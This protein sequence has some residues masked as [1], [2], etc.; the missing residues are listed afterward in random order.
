MPGRIRLRI[1]QVAAVLMLSGFGLAW[2]TTAAVSADPDL[3]ALPWLQ[4]AIGVAISA[5]GA[6]SATLVRWLMA[7]YKE[8]PWYWQGELVKDIVVAVAVGM[9]AYFLG[10]MQGLHSMQLALLLLVA[11]YAGVPL[12][13]G[14]AGRL[15]DAAS[16][17]GGKP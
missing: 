10:A 3:S 7:R 15:I 2:A 12:L 9:G 4:V 8:A 11:G 16:K 6:M 13:S 17:V 14:P 5:W 1:F